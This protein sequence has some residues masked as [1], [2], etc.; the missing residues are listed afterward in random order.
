M[1]RDGNRDYTLAQIIKI[2]EDAYTSL[3]GLHGDPSRA[4]SWIRERRLAALV[5]VLAL[6]RRIERA[7]AV[8]EIYD[9]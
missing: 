5:L 4:A 1:A 3:D 8:V 6:A 2:A 7:G 9:R